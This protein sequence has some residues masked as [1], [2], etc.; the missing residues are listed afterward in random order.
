MIADICQ[1][2]VV[3]YTEEETVTRALY[4]LCRSTLDH[5][6]F[7][8]SL[9]ST[10]PPPEMIQSHPERG[11]AYQLGYERYRRFSDFAVQEARRVQG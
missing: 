11:A 7:G 9:L 1:K 8:D 6:D 5:A 10:F 4:A 3:I 2:D